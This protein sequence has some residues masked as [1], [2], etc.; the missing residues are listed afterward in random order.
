MST[1]LDD[2]TRKDLL[3]VQMPQ[4]KEFDAEVKTYYREPD[5]KAY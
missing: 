5:K 2:D 1:K 3:V 4:S